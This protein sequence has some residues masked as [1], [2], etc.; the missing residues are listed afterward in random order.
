M[1]RRVFKN[2]AAMLGSNI[3]LRAGDLC[4]AVIA[5]RCLPVEEFGKLV[6]V[7]SFY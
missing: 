1:L 2:S 4:V 5:A 6:L 3:V 7:L